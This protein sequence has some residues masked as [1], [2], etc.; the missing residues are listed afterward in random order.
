[1]ELIGVKTLL[2]HADNIGILCTSQNEV[3]N[4][5]KRLHKTSH[6]MGFIIEYKTRYIVKPRHVLP[7]IN[8]NIM[9]YLIRQVE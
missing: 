3:G 9:E 1:M 4:K 8:L 2:A 7:K 5:T 6:N